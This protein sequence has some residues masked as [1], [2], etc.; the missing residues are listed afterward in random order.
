MHEPTDK[1][2]AEV[3]A[4]YSFGVPQADIANFIGVDAKTLRKYYRSELDTAALKANAA[5]AKFLY[6]NASG[7]ALRKGATNADCVR[8]AMFWAKTRMRWRETTH[9]DVTS[10]DR[11]MSPSESRIDAEALSTE[12]LLEIMNARRAG[13]PDE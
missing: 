10:S 6:E 2:R 9:L 11:S 1:T 12:A 13:G 5:V 7:A 4:L 8:A 3:A